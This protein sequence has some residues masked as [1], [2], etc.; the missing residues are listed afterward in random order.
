MQG[1]SK[2]EMEEIL[3]LN[4]LDSGLDVDDI[5]DI[6]NYPRGFTQAEG[7]AELEKAAKAKVSQVL[8]VSNRPQFLVF[9]GNDDEF[10]PMTPQEFFAGVANPIPAPAATDKAVTQAINK[11][12]TSDAIEL[13]TR[14]RDFL[15]KK[16]P[17]NIRLQGFVDKMIEYGQDSA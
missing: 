7:L 14:V 10:L 2:K 1:L 3:G 4:G 13:L 6:A 8:P 5:S 16:Q 12:F 17:P 9:H 11:V 15:R